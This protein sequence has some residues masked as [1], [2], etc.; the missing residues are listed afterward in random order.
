MQ[1]L[2]QCTDKQW[3]TLAGSSHMLD[4]L[5]NWEERKTNY[6]KGR[7]VRLQLGD[8]LD[9]IGMAVDTFQ[10]VVAE[11]DL[12]GVSFNFRNAIKNHERCLTSWCNI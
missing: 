10:T 5:S 8:V 3:D 12:E 9:Q 7:T 4:L 6:E 2:L 1:E 11:F